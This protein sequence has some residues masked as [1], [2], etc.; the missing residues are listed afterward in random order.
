MP[1]RGW[2]QPLKSLLLPFSKEKKKDKRENLIAGLSSTESHSI[3]G[4]RGV[5][6]QGTP[7]LRCPPQGSQTPKGCTHP[8]W[9]EGLAKETARQGKCDPSTRVSVSTR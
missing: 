6:V 8:C 4:M 2:L 7:S 1:G 9:G 5:A 3:H